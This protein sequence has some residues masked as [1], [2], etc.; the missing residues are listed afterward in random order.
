MDRAIS[1]QDPFVFCLCP[2]IRGGSTDFRRGFQASRRLAGVAPL[3]EG[4]SFVRGLGRSHEF[5]YRRLRANW[6]KVNGAVKSAKGNPVEENVNDSFRVLAAGANL[7]PSAMP[8]A[9]PFQGK[10]RMRR[11]LG[12]GHVRGLSRFHPRGKLIVLLGVRNILIEFAGA[13]R[14]VMRRV[15][16]IQHL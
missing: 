1:Q 4:L 15:Q 9:F 12:L 14:V 10:G 7:K 2:R 6:R 5:G 8:P 11:F 13:G 3:R 16:P